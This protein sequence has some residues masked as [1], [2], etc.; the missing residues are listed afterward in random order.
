VT[1]ARTLFIGLDGA[2]FTVLDPLMERG[3]MPFLRD[4]VAHGAR[5]SLRSILP[6]LTPPGWTSLMTGKRP[7]QHGVFDFFQKETP[8]SEFFH[9]ANSHDV[10]SATIWTIASDANKRV[11]SLNFPLMFPAP[12]VNG[13]VVPG[14]WMPWRQLRLGCHPPGLFDRLKG[15]PSFNA[16]ELA[17]DMALEAKAIEGCD[18]EEYEDWI[19]LH[20]R[21]ERRWFDILTYLMREEP[22]DLVGIVFDGVDKLQHL[23]WRFLDPSCQPADPSEWEQDIA[24]KCEGY[25]RQLDEIIAE[26]VALAGPEATIV[27]GSDHGFGPN[28]DV[29]YLNSWL[30]QHGYLAW[31][32]EGVSEPSTTVAQTDA[33]QIGFSQMTRHVYQMDW[34]RTVAYAATPSSQGI[35]IVRSGSRGAAMS[36]SEYARLRAEIAAGLCELTVPSSGRPLVTAVRTREEAFAGP[37]QDLAPDLTLDLNDGVAISILRSDNLFRRHAAPRGNHRPDGIFIAG[38]PGVRSGVTL[39]E[40]SI[41][42]VTPLLLYCLDLPVPDD[43]AGRVPTELFAASEVHNRPPRSISSTSPS[44]VPS[45]PDL[46]NEELDLKREEEEIVLQRLRALGYVE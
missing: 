38:G 24:R 7:G 13:C 14:G 32:A 12:A 16:R 43:V 36:D 34:D 3:V 4:F 20:M 8:E 39:D 23:C 41:V 35:H 33:P 27:F 46:S 17:L 9:F 6:P 2:T 5:A 25:F 22:A 42:D 29:F 31:T 19:A 37:H 10:G 1:R 44:L 18:A 21:R 28:S 40:L 45:I 26:L 15:L 11:I 30:A